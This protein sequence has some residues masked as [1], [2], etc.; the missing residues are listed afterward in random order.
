MAAITLDILA[1]ANVRDLRQLSES[2]QDSADA[3]DEFKQQVSDALA[4]AEKGAGLSSQEFRKLKK[5]VEDAT[6]ANDG[7]LEKGLQDVREAAERAGLEM[8][9]INDRLEYIE[10]S[11]APDR[12][13][14]L[15]RELKKVDGED[16]DIEVDVDKDGRAR[17]KFDSLSDDIKDSANESGQEVAGSFMGG[18]DAENIIEGLTEVMAESTENLSGGFQIAGIAAA[19]GVALIYGELNKVAEK[20]NEAKTQAGEM[21]NEFKGL[22]NAGAIEMLQGQFDELSTSL[23]DVRSW[24]EVWQSDA[25]TSIE[26]IAG[27]MQAG[28]LDAQ[29]FGEAFYETDPTERLERLKEVQEDLNQ[30]L[31]EA[32]HLEWWEQLANSAAASEGSTAAQEAL[33][34]SMSDTVEISEEARDVIGDMVSQ[35]EAAVEVERAQAEAMGLTVEQYREATKQSEYLT[36][37]LAD[38]VVDA[39][40]QA[41]IAARNDADAHREFSDA[42]SEARGAGLDLIDALEEMDD[43]VKD[44]G[45]SL[46]NHSAKG[47]ENQRMFLDLGDAIKRQG[48]AVKAAGGSQEDAN[49]VMEDGAEAL[50][51]NSAALGFNT[52]KV[53]DLIE[54]ITG[55]PKEKFTDVEVDDKGTAK[56]TKEEANRQIDD[57]ARNVNVTVDA[58]TSPLY[59]AIDMFRPPGVTVPVMLQN[60]TPTGFFRD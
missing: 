54:E 39:H 36:E 43:T 29:A 23:A 33:N 53:A 44:N 17:K 41:E 60:V 28:T 55:I 32:G 3:S 15:S 14:E 26:A 59:N 40:E 45:T 11:K 50:Y 34:K 6:Q 46:S 16:I 5:A 49:K 19:A 7:D 21:A 42:A 1:K 13:D 22:D 10:R 24:F 48:D 58:D 2:I 51:A 8:D 31:E 18:F 38:G 27:A 37:A 30:K 52:D 12:I 56:K 47:R 35:Q 4:K 57:V 9:T 25:V 20:I